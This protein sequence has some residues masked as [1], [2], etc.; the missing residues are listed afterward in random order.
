[1]ANNVNT[2]IINDIKLI[3]TILIFLFDEK[4]FYMS[5]INYLLNS[6]IYFIYLSYRV[7]N[8]LWNIYLFCI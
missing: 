2:N 3:L 7:F 6:E 8:Y 1:M 4:I 5:Q